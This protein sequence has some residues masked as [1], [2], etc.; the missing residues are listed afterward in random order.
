[1]EHTYNDREF[2]KKNTMTAWRVLDAALNESV[3]ANIFPAT[4]HHCLR[5]PDV[6][7][8]ALLIPKILGST[9]AAGVC[10]MRTD[11]SPPGKSRE[12]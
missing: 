7:T 1:M 8:V 10:S 11:N 3:V 6:F 5:Q 9:L 2:Q 4:D 12:D